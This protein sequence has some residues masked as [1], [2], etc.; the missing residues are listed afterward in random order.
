MNKTKN[1]KPVS[2]IE[3]K[4]VAQV[5]FKDA[6]SIFVKY[7]F[8]FINTY[9][10]AS[11]LSLH[12]I[13]GY[14]SWLKPTVKLNVVVL[15]KYNLLWFLIYTFLVG[16]LAFNWMIFIPAITNLSLITIEYVLSVANR[17]KT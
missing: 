14:R 9:L 3:P 16:I 10:G 17:S 11:F 8:K 7:W 2:K 4:N 15:Q 1:Q 13:A 12:F 5:V 6:Q